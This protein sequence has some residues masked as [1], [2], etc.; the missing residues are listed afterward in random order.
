[1][2]IPESII[3]ADI[4]F[5]VCEFTP[6]FYILENYPILLVGGNNGSLYL[7]NTLNDSFLYER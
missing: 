7:F 4:I 2:E 6:P 1:M 3:K 5:K